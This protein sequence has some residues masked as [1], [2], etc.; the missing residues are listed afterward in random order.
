[1]DSGRLM[2][3]CLC[4]TSNLRIEL[5]ATVITKQGCL[6]QDRVTKGTIRQKPESAA[7]AESGFGAIFCLT[8]GTI[9]IVHLLA[10]TSVIYQILE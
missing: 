6:W 2:A 5:S 4:D 8:I 10:R 9:M 1:M 7:F 3:G